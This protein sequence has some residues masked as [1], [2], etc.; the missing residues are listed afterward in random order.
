[1]NVLGVGGPLVTMIAG[2]AYK[3]FIDAV[4]PLAENISSAAWWHPA[5]R[6]NGK[7]VFGST[8]NFNKLWAGKFKDEP[9]YAQASAAAAGEIRQRAIETAATVHTATV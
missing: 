5:V 9:D 1:M 8:E 3:E 4:G 6:Y 7:G 2:P